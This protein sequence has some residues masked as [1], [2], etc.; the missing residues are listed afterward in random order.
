M[1]ARDFFN[2]SPSAGQA[3]D[4][5][6]PFVRNQFGASLGGPI[7][8]DKTFFF[9]NA[10]WDR[11]RTTLTDSAVVPTAAF[12][13]GVFDYN[14]Q[15]INLANPSSPSNALGL[16][17]DPTMQKI[18]SLYPN[19][20]GPA[21]DSIR[22]L[23]FF[24]AATPQ[25]AASVTFR[26]DHRFTEKYTVSA[27]FIYG[28]DTAQDST[29]DTLPGIGGVS[30][31]SQSYNG[32]LN[33]IAAFTP[34]L[35]NE[36]RFGL[37]RTSVPFT[38]DG[39]KTIDQTGVLDPF[40]YGTD[41]NFAQSTGVSTISDFGCASLGDSNSQYR[42]YGT[43]HL[44]DNLTWVKGRHNIKV[45]GEFRYI[46]ENG[47]DDF[48]ARPTVDFTAFGNFGINIV[49]CPVA[50]NNPS[51]EVLQTMA[52]AL[53]GVPG[54]QSQTQFFNANGTRTAS[55]YRLLDQHEYGTFVQ[56]SWKVRNNLTLQIGLRYEFDG[57]PF[58]RNG[59][60]SNLLYQQPYDPAPITFQT[61]GPGTGRQIYKDDYKDFEPRLGLAWD[62]LKT[63]KTSFRAGYGI[64]HDRIFGNLFGNLRGDPPFETSPQFF[65]NGNFANGAPRR[66]PKKRPMMVTS[67]P[68][69][70][71]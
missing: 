17:L 14:G 45:G 49:N 57:V 68:A 37:N 66:S 18:F 8:K 62:P 21:V 23:Y 36:F 3:P 39:S 51:D 50:C 32:S 41:Y 65:P 40:G 71:K 64:F 59:N 30:Q 4:P 56:D 42:R 16:P 47:Y 55:D 70:R 38:C 7:V 43:W 15:Q 69:N 33:S 35:V 24:P 1:A 27:R 48:S 63:G 31:T 61:V 6:N 12:K 54:I 26:V 2:P 19:P 52:A 28:G 53:L 20:N 9:V 11:F 5:Q 34:N 29:L 60:L 22:A 58:E 25:N 46:F 67:K 13:S 44:L 10:E